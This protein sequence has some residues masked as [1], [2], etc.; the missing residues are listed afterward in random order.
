M[1]KIVAGMMAAVLLA[2]TLAGCGG[3][4]K[5]KTGFAMVTD[6]SPSHQVDATETDE[7]TVELT[8]VAA[9]ALVGEDGKVIKFETDTVQ[10]KFHYTNDG[11]VTTENNTINKTK[12]ELGAEYGMLPVSSANGIGKEWN[13]QNDAFEKYIIGKTAAEIRA[14]AVTDGKATDEDLASGVTITISTMIEAAA[15][16]VE[17]ATDLGATAN[18]TLGF[19]LLSQA[20]VGEEGALTA[21]NHYGVVTLDK[22][23]KI[24]SSIID[25]SQARAKVEGNTQTADL[26]A[27]VK[28]KL[29]LKEDYN[30]KAASAAAGIGKEWYEQSIAFSDY[31]KGKT[32][33]EVSGLTLEEGRPTGDLASSVTVHVNDWITVLDNA[34]KAAK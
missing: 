8:A 18:D 26:T 4:K 15:L 25:A 9:A 12:G 7:G 23:G 31:A 5:A 27:P 2:G 32:V 30:M 17:N 1:K 22:D 29:V 11:T 19:S 16:A 3:A 34:A 24:T 20:Q 10:T 21:Y 13:E 28:T 33:A 14:I 6:N